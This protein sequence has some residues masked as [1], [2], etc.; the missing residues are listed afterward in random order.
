[1]N[2][3]TW[4]EL[5]RKYSVLDIPCEGRNILLWLDLDVPIS[6][7]APPVLEDE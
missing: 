3:D 2:R 1:M 7:Y 5:Y 4:D 6:D